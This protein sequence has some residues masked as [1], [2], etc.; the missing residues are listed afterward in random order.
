M[1]PTFHTLIYSAPRIDVEELGRV[2]KTLELLLGKEFVVRSDTD[3]S[4]VNKI[5][6]KLFKN[7]SLGQ[8]FIRPFYRLFKT[9]I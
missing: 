2:R 1:D 6:R 5:V 4:C 9:L 7:Y 3:E 8:I